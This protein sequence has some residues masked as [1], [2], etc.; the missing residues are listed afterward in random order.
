MG[1][2]VTEQDVRLPEFRDAKLADLEFRDDGK[3]VRKDRWE[4]GIRTIASDLGLN[5]RSLEIDDVINTARTL[6]NDAEGV[7]GAAADEIWKGIKDGNFF[8]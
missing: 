3:I 1:R 2:D 7:R 5:A 6:A 4:R 8:I